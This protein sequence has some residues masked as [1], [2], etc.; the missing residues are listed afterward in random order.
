MLK[1]HIIKK[2]VKR[3]FDIAVS[4]LCIVLFSW[5][6]SSAG[7]YERSALSGGRFISSVFVVGETTG[8]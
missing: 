8:R 1:L 2:K 6:E 7:I 5:L 4:F 3:I